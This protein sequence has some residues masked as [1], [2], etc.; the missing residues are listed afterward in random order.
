MG[1][2]YYVYCLGREVKGMLGRVEARDLEEDGD[3]GREG[4][5]GGCG[6]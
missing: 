1:F 5:Y 2:V 4:F 3:G 6:V